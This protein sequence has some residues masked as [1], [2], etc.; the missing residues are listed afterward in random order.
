MEP[1]PGAPH[2]ALIR[3]PRAFLLSW[4]GLPWGGAPLT[5]LCWQ[6]LALPQLPFQV[7]SSAAPQSNTPCPLCTLQFVVPSG[8]LCCGEHLHFQVRSGELS[9]APDLSPMWYTLEGSWKSGQLHTHLSKDAPSHNDLLVIASRGHVQCYTI[10]LTETLR[11][12]T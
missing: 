9:S 1:S 8:E 12:Q 4:G 5:E 11:L 6:H 10:L 3:S 2:A 7:P